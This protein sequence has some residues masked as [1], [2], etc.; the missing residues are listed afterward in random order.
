MIDRNEGRNQGRLDQGAT[1]HLI[2][3]HILNCV[4]SLLAPWGNYPTDNFSL[5]QQHPRLHP[6]PDKYLLAQLLQDNYL[7][8]LEGMIWIL[9]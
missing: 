3:R 5:E 8:L 7:R 1:D 6:V 9:F 4:S 2:N